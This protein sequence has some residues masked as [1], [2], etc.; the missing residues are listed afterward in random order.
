VNAAA[1]ESVTIPITTLELLRHGEPEGG[2]RFRGQRDDPLNERGW[3]QLWEAVGDEV[4]WQHIVSSPLQ[5]CSAFA[6]AL[7]DR[8]GLPLSIEPAFKEIGFGVWEGCTPEEL[9]DR[10]GEDY[11]RY[12][13]DPLSFMPPGA[14]PMASFMARVARGW[15]VQLEVHRGRRVLVVCHAGVIRAVLAAVLAVTPERLFRFHIGYGAR[16]RLKMSG[17]GAPTLVFHDGGLP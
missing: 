10:H 1:D 15:E 6:R 12:R 4:P 11:R 7:A 8:H 9:L 17:D 14:E 5:R 16:T 13:A 2:R 3:R